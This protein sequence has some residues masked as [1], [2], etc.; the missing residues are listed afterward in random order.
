MKARQKAVS[1]FTSRVK[2]LL[3]IILVK[4]VY[5]ISNFKVASFR[6]RLREVA[7]FSI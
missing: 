1:I 7:L 2:L 6:L 3:V 4:I 5:E